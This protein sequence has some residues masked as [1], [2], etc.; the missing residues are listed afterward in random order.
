MSRRDTPAR[1]K[2]KPGSTQR[3][4]AMLVM[5][6]VVGFVLLYATLLLIGALGET[7]G[8][9]VWVV[10]GVLLVIGVAIRWLSG[11][12]QRTTR[13]PLGDSE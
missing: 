5:R 8:I 2:E 7:Y 9:G 12:G 13:S 3:T 10:V 11:A 6:W 1:A 4:M